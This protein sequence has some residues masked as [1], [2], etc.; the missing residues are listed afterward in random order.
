MREPKA[1]KKGPKDPISEVIAAPRDFI[2]ADTEV[3]PEVRLED[4]PLDRLRALRAEIDKVLPATALKDINLEDEL[5]RQYQTVKQLQIDVMTDMDTPV[6]Q[7]AQVANSCAA[8]LGQLTK[9][10]TEFYTAERF[11][12]IESI[13]IRCLKTLPEDMVKDF[14]K[15]YEEM[16]A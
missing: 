8:T 10:Q 9:M 4:W 15:M 3:K 11:K 6:N 12:T 2:K 1:P 5:V 16:N 14:F 13:L 7:K